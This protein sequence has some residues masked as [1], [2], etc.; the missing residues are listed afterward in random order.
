MTSCCF[1]AGE[2]SIRRPFP[3]DTCLSLALLIIMVESE[4]CLRSIYAR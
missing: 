3:K 2:V 1:E 4:R